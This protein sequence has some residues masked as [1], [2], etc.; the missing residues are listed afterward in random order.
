MSHR[1][2]FSELRDHHFFHLKYGRGAVIVAIPDAMVSAGPEKRAT[3]GRQVAH[4]FN[5]RCRVESHSAPVLDRIISIS[6]ENGFVRLLL[7]FEFNHSSAPQFQ[8]MKATI[9]RVLPENHVTLEVIR[10]NESST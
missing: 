5:E 2:N 10:T 3:S 1:F 4:R 6:E 9:E 7:E 8:P